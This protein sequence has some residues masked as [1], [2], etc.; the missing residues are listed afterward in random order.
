MRS[1]GGC[2]RSQQ[3]EVPVGSRTNA[4]NA[5][6]GCFRVRRGLT[7]SH[8]V[9]VALLTL[10]MLQGCSPE[11]GEIDQE[12]VEAT[13]HPATGV[14]EVDSGSGG[15]SRTGSVRDVRFVLVVSSQ[16]C[17]CTLEKCRENREYLE[18]ALE[19][20]DL[21][22]RLSVLDQATEEDKAAPLV[23]KYGIRFIPSFLVLDSEG[24]ILHRCDWDIDRAGFE[25][26]LAQVGSAR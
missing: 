23:K 16:A 5:A 22:S 13:S 21:G 17:Q 19:R 14:Q 2:W 12:I 7:A 26:F 6:R 15:I 4:W 20:F 24:R 11:D 18:E 1:G 9:M 10:S 25:E 3:A 8:P